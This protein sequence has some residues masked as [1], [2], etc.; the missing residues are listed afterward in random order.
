MRT[1]YAVERLPTFLSSRVAREG[2]LTLSDCAADRGRGSP[3]TGDME[4]Q[5][6]EDEAH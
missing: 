4:S 3:A 6:G 2:M 5:L 1:S